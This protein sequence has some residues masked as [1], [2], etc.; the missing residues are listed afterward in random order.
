[1][2]YQSEEGATFIENIMILAAIVL[3]LAL[4]GNLCLV[5]MQKYFEALAI[6][7]SLPFP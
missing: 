2:R 6:I 4:I 3:P 7:I 5:A 1:M